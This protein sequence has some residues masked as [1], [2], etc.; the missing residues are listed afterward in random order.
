MLRTLAS[1]FFLTAT[2][3]SET[4]KQRPCCD[5]WI[6][7]PSGGRTESYAVQARASGAV[8]AVEL[9]RD[10]SARLIPDPQAR[11]ALRAWVAASHKPDSDSVLIDAPTSNFS[12]G[13]FPGTDTDDD[14]EARDGDTLV[15]IRHASAHK[16][17]AF[18]DDID[19]LPPEMRAA[20]KAVIPRG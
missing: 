15:L 14:P 16:S 10:G 9:S 19:D 2:A 6:F 17:R 18:V 20:L 4:P 13:P 11:A 3:A 12:I 1:L 7:E 8:V 5:L